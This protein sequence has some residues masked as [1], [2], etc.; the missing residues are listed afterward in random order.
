MMVLKLT[1]RALALRQSEHEV[2][3]ETNLY[4]RL[5]YLNQIF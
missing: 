1:F 3:L 2:L 5:S 4:Y